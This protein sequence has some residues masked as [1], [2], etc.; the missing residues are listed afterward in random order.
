M[1]FGLPAVLPRSEPGEGNAFLGYFGRQGSPSALIEQFIHSTI[2][3]DEDEWEEYVGGKKPSR[4][5]RLAGAEGVCPG[6]IGPV[7]ESIQ[8]NVGISRQRR[9]R[10]KDQQKMGGVAALI[11]AAT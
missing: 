7:Q 10:M 11:E 1:G 4:R 5:G 2:V 9:G 8:S 3:T 6:S